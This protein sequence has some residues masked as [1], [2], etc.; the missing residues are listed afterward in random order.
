VIEYYRFTR[1]IAGE[2]VGEMKQKCKK[3][4]FLFAQLKKK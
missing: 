2:K 1:L 3:I 4:H